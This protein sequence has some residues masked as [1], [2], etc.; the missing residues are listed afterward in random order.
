MES[1]RQGGS[2]WKSKKAMKKITLTQGKE[3]IV[4]DDDY[5]MLMEYKW[6]A[7]KRIT[8]IFYVARSTP[9][10]S[11]GKQKILLLMH[12]EITNAPKGMEV[13]HINGNPLDNRKENLRIC[14]NQQNAMNRG[15]R[16]DN[17]SGY[18]GVSYKKKKSS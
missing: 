9:K 4:D 1:L 2:Y 14:T 10:D 3:A 8:G 16:S 7:Q 18:K 17:T 6:C 11:S 15:K 5:E 13:D 12:R